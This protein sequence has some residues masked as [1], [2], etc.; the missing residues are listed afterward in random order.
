METKE[1]K[2]G[3]QTKE[4]WKGEQGGRSAMVGTA[5]YFELSPLLSLESTHLRPSYFGRWLLSRYC[6][7]S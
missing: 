4:A 6:P 5:L 3:E 7:Y 2:N 1:A